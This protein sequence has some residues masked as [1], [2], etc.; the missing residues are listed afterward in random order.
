MYKPKPRREVLIVD[1]LPT[2][3]VLLILL[4]FIVIN[5]KP[6]LRCPIEITPPFTSSNLIYDDF[7]GDMV[8]ILIAQGKVMLELPGN[9]IREQ[10]LKQMGVLYSI[11][12]LPQEITKFGTTDI[13]GTPVKD[14][15]K[16][17]NGYY[18]PREYYAQKG[19][20]TDTTSNELFNWLY[21]SRTAYGMLAGKSLRVS[22]KADQN[23]NYTV[24]KRI[25]S[26]LQSQKVNKFTLITSYKYSR[27]E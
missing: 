16:Y 23:T 8:T 9:N 7:D 22:I 24:I 12:F 11:S 3:N 14:L 5:G 1:L 18:D 13:I 19:L 17:I 27:Y 6:K 4:M 26:I 25:I 10:A 21:A 15:R 2:V 20:M